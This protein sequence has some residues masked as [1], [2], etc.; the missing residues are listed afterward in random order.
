MYPQRK[1]NY[2][3]LLII[4]TSTLIN[5]SSGQNSGYLG[6]KFSA[7]YNVAFSM[8]LKNSSN[9]GNS[10]LET[11]GSANRSIWSFNIINGFHFDYV[12]K[13]RLS[14]GIIYSR[15]NT[16][17]DG[18]NPVYYRD[19]TSTFQSKENPQNF[20]TIKMNS[21]GISVKLFFRNFIAPLGS[22][23]KL[24]ALLKQINATYNPDFFYVKKLKKN[25]ILSDY[26]GPTKQ[27]IIRPE[28][29]FSVGEQRIYFHR[30]ILDLGVRVSSNILVY[31][32]KNLIQNTEAESIFNQYKYIQ[33][34]SINRTN[35]ANF[36]CYYAGI[37]VL[38]F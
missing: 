37:S 15:L 31:P 6:K 16:Q 13:R 14:I 23:I 9:S 2:Q 10:L 25:Q 8:A 34:T 35:S 1:Y 24:D 27:T 5:S 19:P 29:L 26:L 28:L 38:I 30:I 36:F 4:L 3:F 17:Y 32:I 21:L 11:G 20:Y 12:V 33:T 22:Y 18:K 7:G